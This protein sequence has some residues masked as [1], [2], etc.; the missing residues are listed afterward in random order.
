V[1]VS[2]VL[3]AEPARFDDSGIDEEV[4]IE[5]SVMIEGHAIS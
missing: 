4:I 3:R 2:D 5:T 1:P